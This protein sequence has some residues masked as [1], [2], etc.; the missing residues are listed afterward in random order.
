MQICNKSFTWFLNLPNSYPIYDQNLWLLHPIYDL[1][2][3]LIFMTVAAGTV[4]LLKHRLWKAISLLL[5]ILGP[6]YMEVR[7]PQVGEVTC[8]GE[9]TRLSI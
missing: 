6:V 3:N 2:K 1:T 7:G 4:A 9:V 8:L 5:T